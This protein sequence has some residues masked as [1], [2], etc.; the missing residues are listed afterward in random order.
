MNIKLDI[1]INLEN[2]DFLVKSIQ[3]IISSPSI[4][5]INSKSIISDTQP[6][7][8][9]DINNVMSELSQNNRLTEV[10]EILAKYNVKRTSQLKEE[11]LESIYKDFKRLLS[12]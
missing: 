8:I 9:Q 12:N 5:K 6:I 1:N 11:N 7:T 2:I 3:N 10:K 4:H